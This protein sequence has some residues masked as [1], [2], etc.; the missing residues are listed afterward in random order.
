MEFEETFQL[1][2]AASSVWELLMDVHQVAAC[3]DGA[4][5]VAVVAEDHYTGALLVRMGPVKLRFKGDVRVTARDAETLTGV[6]EAQARDARMGGGFKASLTM[7]LAEIEPAKTR[8]SIRLQTTFLGRIGELGRPLI[9]KKVSVM[10]ADFA[11]KVGERVF[12]EVDSGAARV[13]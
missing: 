8:L 12:V 6:L 10:L 13:E 7:V 3:M 5:D 4:E 1:Q 9:K 11:R 2:A